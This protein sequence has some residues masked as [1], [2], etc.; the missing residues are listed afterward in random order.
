MALIQGPVQWFMFQNI[1]F[2]EPACVAIVI[3]LNVP[4]DVA[5]GPIP[6][7][8]DQLAEVTGDSSELIG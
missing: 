4:E 3:D 7:S 5:P 1:A 8:L 2:H 6:T